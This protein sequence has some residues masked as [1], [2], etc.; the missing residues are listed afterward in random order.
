MLKIIPPGSFDFGMPVASLVDIHRRGVDAD[1]MVKRASVLTREMAQIRPEANS[2]VIHLISLGAQEHY[3]CFVAGTNVRMADSSLK[4]IEQ[5]EV[6]QR[7]VT[8][9]GRVRKV[10]SRF[11]REYIGT[12]CRLS[13]AGILDDIECTANHQFLVL[14]REQVACSVDASKHCKPATCR[15]SA[16]CMARSCSRSHVRYAPELIEAGSIRPGD[17]VLVS[18][19]D[20]GVGSQTWSWSKELARVL[21]YFLAEGSYLKDKKGKRR[22]LAFCFNCNEEKTLAADLIACATKLKDD[23]VHLSIKG[24][25]I[26]KRDNTAVVHLCCI[27]LAERFYGA[28]GEYSGG[29]RLNGPV[30]MQTPELLTE[31]LACYLDGDGTCPDYIK[32]NGYEE[33]R[34]TLGTKSRALALDLQWMLGRLNCPSAVCAVLAKVTPAGDSANFYHVSFSNDVGE[35]FAGKCS[36]HCSL[37]PKQL[38]QHSF[39]WNGYVCRPVRAITKFEAA[40]KVYNLEVEEDHTYTVSNGIVVKNC[41]RNGDGFNEKRG[42]FELVEPKKGTPKRLELGG[43]LIEFHPTFAKHA[44]VFKHHKNDDPVK[45]I[46]DVLAEAYNPEMKRGE[47]LIRVPHD[48]EWMADLE[49]LASGGEIPFSMATKVPFDFC[50][51]CGNRARTRA[52]Y[53][54]HLNN[55]MTDI[56]KTGHQ[57]FAINDRPTFFDISKVMRPADRIAYSLQKVARF[58]DGATLALEQGLRDPGLLTLPSTGANQKLAMARKLAAIEKLVDGVARGAENTHIKQLIPGACCGN[59]PGDEM[60]VLKSVR[61]GTALQALSDAKICLSVR[62]FLG[63]VMGSKSDSMAGDISLV[64]RMLPGLHG[65]L[66]DAGEAEE[67]AT[68]SAY[69]S[70]C[71]SIPRFVREVV[72]RLAGDHSLGEE[73]VKHRVQITIIRGTAPRLQIPQPLKTAAVSNPAHLAR[74]YAKYQLSFAREAADN[75]MVSDLI[76]LKNYMT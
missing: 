17:Y 49:K 12:L 67:C 71:T 75:E 5:I 16:T 13:V 18:I 42:Y 21:G 74:E 55:Q 72:G 14:P 39:V 22:G 68:D 57:V 43:G 44:H 4:A 33:Q 51:V 26:Y 34:Y 8:G 64:E 40:C 70:A 47:L 59:I 29:I 3:G 46:G 30:W 61:L 41:N 73:P 53:C 36:K 10:L 19:P 58:A 23:Y 7:V 65:R 1:W 62:D 69:D 2:S 45:K 76:A 27:E 9:L 31:M 63:L 50:T 56:L 25:Y 60:E 35:I 20:R 38:K 28:I 66:L 15:T 11:E 32:P 54:D 6:N 52:D 48:K 37:K 24:P